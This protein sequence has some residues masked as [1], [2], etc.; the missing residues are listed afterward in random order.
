MNVQL[1][2][3]RTMG[4][5]VGVALLAA[6]ATAAP[7]LKLGRAQL[8]GASTVAVP[9]KL[10]AR[11]QD[12]VAALNFTLRYDPA[13]LEVAGREVKAGQAVKRARAELASKAEQA[14]G[15][16]RVLV[17]PE[18]SPDFGVLRGERVATVY[19]RF[20]GPVPPAPP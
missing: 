1:R 8:V 14:T 7:R 15:A 3:L 18:F 20:R 10:D 16:V 13:L 11:R 19:L 17:V 9:V 2:R 6:P 4:L 5:I 12:G